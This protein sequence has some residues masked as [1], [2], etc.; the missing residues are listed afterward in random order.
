MPRQS[1]LSLALVS[2]ATFVII[3]DLI[4]TNVAFPFIEEEFSSTP[5]STLAWV[6]S[7]NSIAAA[8]LL[9]LAG[10]L[11]DRYGRRRI[12]LTGVAVF[13]VISAVTAAAPNPAVLIAARVGQGAGAA[14]VTSTA[15]ALLIPLFPVAKRGLAVGIWGTAASAGAA[16]GPTLGAVAIEAVD[17]RWAF[18]IN[19]PIGMIVLAF[20]RRVLRET[21]RAA[22]AG[23]IDFLGT[24]VGTAAIGLLTFGVLQGPRWGWSSAAV[25]SILAAAV[26][27]SVALVARCLTASSPLVDLGLFNDRKFAL[28]NLSQAGTQLAINAWFFTTPLFLINVWGYSALAGGAAVAVGMVV[29]FVSIPVGHWS[30]RHG[31]RGVLALGGIIAAAGMLVWVFGVEDSP[32]FW[33]AYLLGLLIFGLGAGMVGIV[34]TNAALTDMPDQD[35]GMGNAVFQTIRRLMGAIGVALAVVLIGD[36]S[37]ESVEAFRRVWLLIAGGYLFSVL[38]ILRYP[39]RKAG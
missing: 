10:R 39:P 1:W 27:L 19:V 28:A 2:A 36:R 31:Y 34:V 6:S 23:P 14:M 7:G 24:V 3:L 16:T 9:L 8:A 30:D 20:G 35:L 37:N 17:W 21:E 25:V 18:L 38:A 4:A 12:F 5:R 29:S 11:G 13:T 33:S 15:I 22:A 26:L 32:D